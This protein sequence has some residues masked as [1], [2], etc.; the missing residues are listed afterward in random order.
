VL[1]T[2]GVGVRA[3]QVHAAIVPLVG[4]E[5]F[6]NLL[7]VVQDGERRIEREIGAGFDPRAMPALLLVIMDYRH[8]LG[9]DPAEARVLKPRRALLL[10]NGIRRRL[11]FKFQ[12]HSLASR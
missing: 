10:R 8:V 11:D 2:P 3:E 7:R 1:E 6:E 4:L 5:A 9:E 12:T